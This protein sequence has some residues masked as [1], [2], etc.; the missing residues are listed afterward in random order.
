MVALKKWEFNYSKNVLNCELC[1]TD[2]V[3]WRFLRGFRGYYFMVNREK[4]EET[5]L[6]TRIWD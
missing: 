3:F 6:E 4:N 2:K 1:G 5:L